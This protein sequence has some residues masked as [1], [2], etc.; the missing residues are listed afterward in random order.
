MLL[1]VWRAEPAHRLGHDLAVGQRAV[2]LE[3]GLEFV[4]GTELVGGRV[5]AED[6][7]QLSPDAGVP[8]DQCPVA[9]E[10][11]P[12]RHRVS[13]MAHGSYARRQRRFGTAVDESLQSCCSCTLAPSR[14]SGDDP[15]GWWVVLPHPRVGL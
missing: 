6:A 4:V 14:I 9:V 1:A 15:G 5:I 2:V 13:L 8:V 3:L 12:P 7:C 11:R 10:A